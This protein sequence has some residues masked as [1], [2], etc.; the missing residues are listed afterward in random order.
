MTLGCTDDDT[1][2][3]TCV[4][5]FEE[6]IGCCRTIERHRLRAERFGETQQRHPSVAF[7]FS[8]STQRRGLDVHH[9]PLGIE[10]IGKTFASANG[11]FGLR[12]RPGGH[13]DPI[14]YQPAAGSGLVAL[15]SACRGLDTVRGPAKRKLTQGEQIGPA[16]KVFCRRGGVLGYV[17]LA[18]A[19]TGEEIIGRQIDELDFIGFVEHTIGQRLTLP[20]AGSLRHDI[21]ETFEML[22]IDGG[23]Y[24]DSRG[25]NFFDVLPALRVS[26]SRLSANR[27][28]VGQLVDEQNR[29]STFE[30]GVEVEFLA[31]DAA[32]V[33]W[34][35]RQLL[36]AL[37]QPLGFR[38]SMR[39]DVT[40]D[41]VRAGGASASGRLQ[42]RVGLADA[43]DRAKEDAQ[44]AASRAGFLGL[45]LRQNSS[46]S[47]R[48]SAMG[49]CTCT[50]LASSAR[51]NSSTF[52]R[53]SPSKPKVRPSV[54]AATSART[55]SSGI[56]RVRATRAIW[57]S[58]AA[59][60]MCGSR[61]LAEAVT[62]STGIGRCVFRVGRLQRGDSIAHGGLEVRVCRRLIRARR[63][64]AI[65]RLRRRCRWSRPEILWAA[66][67]LSEQ[68]R[69]DDLAVVLDEAAAGLIGKEY[70][71]EERDD[72]GVQRAGDERE[73][74]EDH[75]G[76]A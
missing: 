53:G 35:R 51:F 5:I 62:R 22:H 58:A 24:V 54:A 37:H 7:F 73:Q 28:R 48:V 69:A 46:G 59:G 27:I 47:G 56:P 32:I 18:G 49:H 65:V 72:A 13:Q 33:H 30:R 21:V 6:R 42:H 8:Q 55:A 31:Y 68:P 29:R 76:G 3:M 19:Q 52:T 15:R 2:H 16:K 67:R 43:R 41:N 66:E 45:D 71:A 60:E 36:K 61:P 11:L 39:L 38:T 23:P 40:D 74:R 64:G 26:G 1:R 34:Q 20:H 17:D 12:V 70:I 10:R 57:Y 44:P 25:E 14:A 63:Y 75:E 9:R 50:S 4:S